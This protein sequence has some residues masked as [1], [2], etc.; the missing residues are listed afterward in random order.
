M[1]I[2]PTAI[3]YVRHS[4]HFREKQKH[5]TQTVSY[6]TANG[7]ERIQTEIYLTPKPTMLWIYSIRSSSNYHLEESKGEAVL[8]DEVCTCSLTNT[9]EELL[10]NY[11]T[12]TELEIVQGNDSFEKKNKEMLL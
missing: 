5:K 2:R 10:E 3:K 9:V 12:R 4:P 7:R 8:R 1:S 11:R 6:S